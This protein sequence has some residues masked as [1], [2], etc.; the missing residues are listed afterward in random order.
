[1]RHLILFQQFLNVKPEIKVFQEMLINIIMSWGR[2]SFSS[3]CFL[4]E[5]RTVRKDPSFQP[6]YVHKLIPD[7]RQMKYLSR[8]PF[9]IIIMLKKMSMYHTDSLLY[10]TGT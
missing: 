5:Y 6:T 9:D 3:F 4:W 8:I 1:M 10:G 2:N 7:G